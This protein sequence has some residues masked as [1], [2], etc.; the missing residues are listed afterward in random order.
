LVTIRELN[1]A[2]RDGRTSPVKVTE[3]YLDSIERLNPKLNCFITV[4][5]GSSL[6]QA[7]E[8]EK[9]MKAGTLLGPLQGVPVAIKDLIYIE[10]V[11]CTAGSRIL[12]ES[13]AGYDA[14]LV[15]RLK[16]AGAVI[17][18]TTNLHE[19]AAGITNVNPHYGP[20]RNPWDPARISGGS[21][22]GSAAAVS[23]GLA[24]AAIGTDTA[25]SVRLPAGLCGVVGLKPTYG[26]ISRIGVIPLASSFDTVGTLTRSSWDAAAL[27][28]AV[29]GHD[30][31]DVSTADVPLPDYVPEATAPLGQPK[32]GV[33]QG[34]FLEGLEAGVDTEFRAFLS[35]L[36][37][38]G[39]SV[40]PMEIS[41]MAAVQD[42][43]YP[44]RRAEASAFHEKWLSTE[45][46]LYGDD[47]R[48]TLEL[49]ARIP[50]TQYINAQNSRPALR[51]AFLGSMAPFDVLAAPTSMI[52]APS[53]GQ[54][55]IELNGKE[56][57]VQ[58]TLVRLTLPFNVVGFPAVS[59]PVGLSAGLPVGAQLVA[60]P[61]DEALLL[62]LANAY[63]ERFGNFPD[64]PFGVPQPPSA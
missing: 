62:R 28:S 42:I 64:P 7:E 27:L 23:A 6:A 3:R 11:K 18:G 30:E 55:S 58:S 51:E 26:L 4:L 49:G 63:E 44:I 56:A 59:L 43:F 60:R 35:R 13:V 40:Q 8:A 20:V 15:R 50:A 29:A 54:S 17:L 39:C 31:G 37:Q 36:T 41:A 46:N 25:G 22:G 24:G 12:A 57:D 9:Q 47:V 16:K 52:T 1:R 53:I 21:S 61:F 32:V 38:I 33:P 14:Y 34:Y 45:A 5:R 19:F 10:G 2:Y 48:R